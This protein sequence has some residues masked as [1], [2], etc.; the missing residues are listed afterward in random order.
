MQFKITRENSIIDLLNLLRKTRRKNIV[1]FISDEEN[2]LNIEK[3]RSILIKA[4]KSLGKN[5]KIKIHDDKYFFDYT[6]SGFKVEISTEPFY[7]IKQIDR[8]NS[9]LP[10]EHELQDSNN[11]KNGYIVITTALIIGLLI[12]SFQFSFANVKIT[13]NLINKTTTIR[14]SFCE[15]KCNRPMEINYVPLEHQIAK[16]YEFIS[17]GQKFSGEVSKGNATFYNLYLGQTDLRKNTRIQ[18]EE[19]LVFIAQGRIS[20][21]PAK[22]INGKL[23]PGEKVIPIT[24]DE[25]DIFGQIIGSR[26]NIE[27]GNLFLPGLPEK[28]RGNIW[29]E[30]KEPLTGG[31]S[32]STSIVSKTDIDEFLKFI[33]KDIILQA[34]T[35]VRSKLPSN[36]PDFLIS[37][38]FSEY[39]PVTISLDSIPKE[40]EQIKSKKVKIQANMTLF[41]LPQ[42]SISE[43]VL[44]FI[45]SHVV[46]DTE[47]FYSMSHEN[48]EFFSIKKLSPESMNFE[49]DIEVS[50]FLKRKINLT[51]QDTEFLSNKLAGATYENARK[52]I[53]ERFPNVIL[54]FSYW[55]PW[56]NT[57]PFDPGQIKIKTVE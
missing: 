34:I 46:E 9:K 14:A 17:T 57:F 20:I 49:A 26:G 55:P 24:A 2:C 33:K 21:P 8:Y 48:M 11:P 54:Q 43:K 16:E 7:N 29:A 31:T 12:T 4:A 23:V 37:A 30:I 53:L 25:K 51:D 36:Y 39:F 15:T 3:N 50:Y 22:Y 5:I 38:N 19:G 41:L 35:E 32:I 44:G 56:Q 6:K 28:E 10:L 1:L 13:P 40:N 27:S 52:I 45:K 47:E 18:T 42:K